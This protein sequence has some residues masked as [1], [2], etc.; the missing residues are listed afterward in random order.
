MLTIGAEVDEIIQYVD[1]GG[2]D[3]EGEKRRDCLAECKKVETVCG[4]S[5]DQ[6]QGVLAH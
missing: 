5:R 4:R 6:N 2:G 1:A 3:R